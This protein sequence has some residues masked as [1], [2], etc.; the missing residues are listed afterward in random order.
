MANLDIIEREGLLDRGLEL[1]GEIERALRTLEGAPLVGEVRAGLGAL[2]AVA[3]APD[4][5]AEAPDLPYR[6]FGACRERGLFIRPI[7]DGVAFSP[8]LVITRDEVDGAAET[9]GEALQAV[10]RDVPALSSRG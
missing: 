2:G 9:L 6:L 5:L 3:F 1:E 4:A 8:P 7:G 10:A